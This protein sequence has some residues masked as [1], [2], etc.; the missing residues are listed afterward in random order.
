MLITPSWTR[1]IERLPASPKQHTQKHQ[2]H[3]VGGD[4]YRPFQ[5]TGKLAY[6]RP[7][8]I[9]GQ[10]SRASSS[11]PP[12]ISMPGQCTTWWTC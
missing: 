1:K 9:L 5:D 10:K 4:S 8:G 3:H 12:Y 11:T 7:N 2:V 6:R